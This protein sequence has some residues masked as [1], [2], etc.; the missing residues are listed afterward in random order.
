MPLREFACKGCGG[1]IEVYHPSIDPNLVPPP[2]CSACEDT[3]M[4]IL[5]SAPTVDTADNFHPFS[6]RGPDGRSWEITN[7]HKLRQVEHAYLET[8][9]DVRFD[10]YS[11]NP[12]N[13][14]PV[15]GFGPE[16]HP[17]D[18]NAALR[19]KSESTVYKFPTMKN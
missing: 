11:A 19:P 4:C 17:Q 3:P 14:D 16:Y 18:K 1:F 8:G 10:A 9:H 7:L 6:Y 12:S 15:D 2:F 13:P 5:W